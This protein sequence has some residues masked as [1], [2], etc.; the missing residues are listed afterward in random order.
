M[1]S[2]QM[3]YSIA[4]VGLMLNGTTIDNIAFGG[5]AWK[6]R[7][8]LQPGDVILQVPR[9]PE[10]ES[11]LCLLTPRTVMYFFQSHWYAMSPLH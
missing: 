2:S 9:A 10:R 6:V 3:F 4:Q 7:D 8:E 11:L 5:P 1:Y